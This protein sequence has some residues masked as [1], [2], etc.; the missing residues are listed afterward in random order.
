M[1]CS[2]WAVAYFVL[3]EDVSMDGDMYDIRRVSKETTVKC[4]RHVLYACVSSQR[5]N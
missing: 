5:R 1:D 4:D 2:N 3:K